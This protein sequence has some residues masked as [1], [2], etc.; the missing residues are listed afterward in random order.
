[1]CENGFAMVILIVSGCSQCGITDLEE[2]I[3]YLL[4]VGSA[5]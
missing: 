5:D 1:M 3:T 2:V 4:Q